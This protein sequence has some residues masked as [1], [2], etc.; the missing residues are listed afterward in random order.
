M[1]RAFQLATVVALAVSAGAATA[2]Q[3]APNLRC[4]SAMCHSDT[5][6]AR[7]TPGYRE[8]MGE[9]AALQR[10]PEALLGCADAELTRQEATLNRLDGLTDMPLQR[11]EAGIVAANRANWSMMRER[12]CAAIGLDYE[13]RARDAVER[14]CKVY[15]TIE[16][17]IFLEHVAATQSWF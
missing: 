9:K 12:F 4:A 15:I 11:E 5:A 16:R 17:I 14:Q 8:C 7:L 3:P 10:E 6:M 1:K 2:S 13:G